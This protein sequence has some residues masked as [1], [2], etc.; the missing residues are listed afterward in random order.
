MGELDDL[1]QTLEVKELRNTLGGLDEAEDG[2]GDQLESVGIAR[3]TEA[4]DQN[5]HRVPGE[6]LLLH[7]LISLNEVGEHGAGVS[8]DPVVRILDQV[9]GLAHKPKFLNLGH[10]F[11]VLR[12]RIPNGAKG[13]RD[14][15]SIRVIQE[16]EGLLK[17]LRFMDLVPVCGYKRREFSIGQEA[18]PPLNSFWVEASLTGLEELGDKVEI[19]GDEL[20]LRGEEVLNVG[21][22]G[23]EEGLVDAVPLRVRLQSE[24]FDGG[25]A[26][27]DVLSIVCPVELANSLN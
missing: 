15:L 21:L 26:A 25:Q 20:E 1:L 16:R 10:I 14:Q 3:H 12:N 2:E 6:Q 19:G 5:L 24:L 11:L 27:G 18:I 23:G 8:R 4:V 7:L 17:H 9:K 13:S 22:D